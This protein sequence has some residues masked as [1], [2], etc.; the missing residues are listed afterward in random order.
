MSEN[1]SYVFRDLSTLVKILKISLILCMVVAAA[2]IWS[3]WL[4][5]DLLERVQSGEEISYE[6]VESNDSREQVISQIYLPS[7]IVTMV[8]FL[9]WV[10]M[11]SRNAHALGAR[12]MEYSPGWT[13]AWFFIP[14]AN[15]WVP[16]K[17]VKEIFQ[18]SDPA[19]TDDWHHSET[20]FTLPIWW[21]LNICSILLWRYI[22]SSSRNYGVEDSVPEMISSAWMSIGLDTVNIALRAVTLILVTT[23]VA[24]QSKKHKLVASAVEAETFGTQ[25]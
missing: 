18:A 24:W 10:F 11:S 16:Y 17:G 25:W 9:V 1:K 14:I 7:V 3:S 12:G 2:S 20:P 19:H 21:A 4:H 15:L 5:I 23:L 13:V 8:I 22:T 6:F